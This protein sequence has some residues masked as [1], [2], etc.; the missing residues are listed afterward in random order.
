MVGEDPSDLDASVPR[1][2][3][4]AHMYGLPAEQLLPQEEVE[5]DLTASGATDSPKASP[6]T[7]IVCGNAMNQRRWSSPTCLP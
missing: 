7:S 6:S 3:R 5:V 2:M 1:L 4:L